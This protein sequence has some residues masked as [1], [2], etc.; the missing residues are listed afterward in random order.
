MKT[1]A[2][3]ILAIIAGMM[4]FS[5]TAPLSNR[6]ND[7]ATDAESNGNDW[8]EH[9]WELSQEE[10]EQLLNE[11]EENYD[12]YTKEERAAIN[13]AIGRYNGLLIKRGFQDAG[14]AIKELGEQIPSVVEGFFS[15]FGDD[16]E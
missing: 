13:K 5:C 3:G 15:A 6:L 7:L 12:T 10:Y 1:A 11:Y 2:K 8:T 14:N 4:I 9:Q 16:E